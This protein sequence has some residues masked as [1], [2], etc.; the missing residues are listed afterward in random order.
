MVKPLTIIV[1]VAALCMLGSPAF[2][3]HPF[4]SIDKAIDHITDHERLVDQHP[5]KREHL[6]RYLKR[7]HA[8][9]RRVDHYLS[10]IMRHL[11]RIEDP[12]KRAEAIARANELLDKI[13]ARLASTAEEIRAKIN[14]LENEELKAK[15]LEALDTAV[16]KATH[17]INTTRERINEIG[18]QQT[19]PMRPVHPVDSPIGPTIR[20]AISPMTDDNVDHPRVMIGDKDP[21]VLPPGYVEKAIE[22]L[23]QMADGIN[24]KAD[25]T[26]QRIQASDL[27]DAQKAELTDKVNHARTVALARLEDVRKTLTQAGTHDHVVDSSHDRPRDR[28]T[29]HRVARSGDQA[30][31]RKD[32]VMSLVESKRRAE[33]T[34]LVPGTGGE[35]LAEKFDRPTPRATGT[36]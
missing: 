3:E 9:Y 14:G 25:A 18:V 6:H 16:A 17:L 30:E 11:Q 5:P 10:V 33:Q 34:T 31:P 8:I 32:R 12:Q 4:D 36:P 21:V 19:E 13:E 23:D 26:I 35:P 22:R 1:I 15:A 2:A 29:D 24:G 7:L 27:S 28:D 20:P